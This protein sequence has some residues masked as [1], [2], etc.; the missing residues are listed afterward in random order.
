MVKGQDGK[1]FMTIIN[2]NTLKFAFNVG[3]H[4][5]EKQIKELFVHINVERCIDTNT[6]NKQ[7]FFISHRG[8][9]I[10]W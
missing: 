5:K 7:R 9:G 2:Q 3:L 1:F 10:R 4:L 8:L 6:K